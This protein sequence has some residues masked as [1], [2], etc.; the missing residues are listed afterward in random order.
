[1][2]NSFILIFCV[3]CI[4]SCSDKEEPIGIWDDNI[5][6]STKKAEFVSGADS[7]TIATEGSGWWIDAIS[8]EG[9]TYSYYGNETVDLE[10]NSYS[11]DEIDFVVEKRNKNALFVKIEKNTTGK[12]RELSITFQA[13]NY[14]DYL[15]IVQAAK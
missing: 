3:F 4:F 9:Y 15:T 10:A 1:M 11:I 8:F 7:V 5:K 14:F 2:N 13:G 12:E 6:L